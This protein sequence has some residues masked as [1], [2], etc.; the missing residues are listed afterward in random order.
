MSRSRLPVVLVAVLALATACGGGQSATPAAPAASSQARVPVAVSVPGAPAGN[1]VESVVRSAFLGATAVHIKGS[2][3]NSTGS[4]TMDLQLNKDDT[5]S[6]T[7]SE[8][9][10]DIPLIAVGGKYYVKFTP[11][12]ISQSSNA[13]VGQVGPVLDN[14]W[15]SSDSPLATDMVAGVKPLLTYDSF[16]SNMFGQASAAPTLTGTDVVNNTTV[17]V[18]ESS[19]GSTVY[20]ARSSPHFLERMTAPA[21]GSGE[22]DFT[23]WNQPVPVTAP[24]AAQIYTGSGA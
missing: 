14:K 19:D 7:I 16:V 17:L 11:Q 13:A 3:S 2:L 12:L 23:G 1:Q 22:L 5:A 24:P 15:V 6:G 9:G 21:S 10:A 18:Y 8:G 20:I 4:L